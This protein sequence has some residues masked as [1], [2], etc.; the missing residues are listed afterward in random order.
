MKMMRAKEQW[1][2]YLWGTG[3]RAPSD[4][5][6]FYTAPCTL[7]WGESMGS[8]KGFHMKFFGTIFNIF[9]H[10]FARDDTI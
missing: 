3:A 9:A 5:Q 4:F 7:H 6:N 2:R 1:R 8:P 10:I